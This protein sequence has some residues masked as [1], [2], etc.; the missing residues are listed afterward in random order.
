[1]RLEN[2]TSDDI[3]Y[4]SLDIECQN[5]YIDL[6]ISLKC[7][8]TD[9]VYRN[10]NMSGKHSVYQYAWMVFEYRVHDIKAQTL[11]SF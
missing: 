11:C 10:T 1:M 9:N 5:L 4:T 6:M 3:T 7:L 2:N 8:N